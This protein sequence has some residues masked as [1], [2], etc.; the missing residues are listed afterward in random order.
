MQEANRWWSQSQWK[1]GTNHSFVSI[2]PA[3]S[4][5][6]PWTGFKKAG[7]WQLLRAHWDRWGKAPFSLTDK[8]PLYTQ[9]QWWPHGQKAVADVVAQVNFLG[10]TGLP[11]FTEP[12]KMDKL[13]IWGSSLHFFTSSRRTRNSKQFL[14]R[15]TCQKLLNTI[16]NL[17]CIR[18][19]KKCFPVFQNTSHLRRTGEGRKIKEL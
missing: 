10:F 15:A 9:F 7:S 11:L 13:H 2:L 8:P 18:S 4:A 3:K 5:P 12:W 17:I 16:Q 19:N 14:K 1:G 6:S